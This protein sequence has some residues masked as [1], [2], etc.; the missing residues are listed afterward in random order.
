MGDVPVAPFPRAVHIA[1]LKRQPHAAVLRPTHERLEDLA[2]PGQRLGHGP[3][4]DPP[5]EAADQPAAEPL[6][7]VD[8]PHPAI[9]RLRVGQ[10]I[11][12]DAQRADDGPA[13]RLVE[14][15]ANLPGKLGEVDVADVMAEGQ[16]KTLE[17]VRQDLPDIAGRVAIGLD[18]RADA[19]VFVGVHGG[20]PVV[21]DCVDGRLS[22]VPL[23]A[24]PAVPFPKRL[25]CT[26]GRASSGTLRS[27][28][29]C[30]SLAGLPG[31]DDRVHC[32]VPDA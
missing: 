10:R 19:D 8:Q 14:H 24:R 23:L 25:T 30:R 11:A 12:I 5:G 4:R 7:R 13:A 15:L 27:P 26:A 31:H 21:A 18:Q 9:G 6:G 17:P 16:L 28:V 20:I 1:V 32:L 29:G 22:R 2:Q 3:V